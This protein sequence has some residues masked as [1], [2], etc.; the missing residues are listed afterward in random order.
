VT[1]TLAAAM[2]AMHQD[3]PVL[4]T[5]QLAIRYRASNFTA[6]REMGASWR[7]ITD[8]VPQPPGIH[9]EK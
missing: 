9:G 1:G 6:M 4:E 7:I 5:P 8:Q 3:S 2:Q